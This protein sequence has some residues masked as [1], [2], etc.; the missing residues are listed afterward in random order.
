MRIG[1]V[2][3]NYPPHPGGLETVVHEL[4]ERFARRHAVV[5]VSTEWS[6]ERGVSQEGG[7]VVHRLRA[8]HGAERRGVPYA[9][10]LGPGLPAAW[11]ALRACDVI[12]AHGSLY[13][14]TLLGLTARRR[15][16]PLVITEHVGFV[17]YPSRAVN[18]IQRFA[19]FAIGDRVARRAVRVVA[20]NVRVRDWLAE[21]F[22]AERAG[23]I[24]NGV[25]ADAFTPPTPA[26]RAAA[27]AR[28]GIAAH[29]TVGLFVGRAAGK[30]N[31]DAVLG[32][33]RLHY[34][35]VVCGAERSLPPDVLDLGVLPH[36]A[37]PE[38]FAAADFLLHA[39]TGEGFPV[40][41][42]EAMAS[43]LPVALLWDA[44]YA[45]SVSRDAVL[46]VDSLA[47]LAGEAERLAADG[48]LR[49]RLSTLARDLA[50]DRWGWG[51]AVDSYL[52]IF[53]SAIQPSR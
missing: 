21:R 8:W 30:K 29:E 33:A 43:G 38:V 48:A 50:V 11:K 26:A 20:V 39:A 37:M 28:F 3:H 24:A 52:E 5:V 10:P 9:L 23:F 31:L 49:A 22:G 53:Q 14:T 16:V 6:G 4:A 19:W 36:R 32:F 2:T 18:A 47:E 17:D 12:H 51:R 45:G 44:G 7:L 41:V 25:D 35:L 40:A 13:A 46:A 42:Q 27:R 15:G 34:R 1:I